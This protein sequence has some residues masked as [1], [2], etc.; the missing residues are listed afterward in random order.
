MSAQPPYDPKRAVEHLMQVTGLGRDLVRAAIRSGELPGEHVGR[1][2]VLPK[3][4]F[5]RFL[6][7]EWT[8]RHRPILE[9][10]PTAPASLIRRKAS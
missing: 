8:P 7:G 6:A 1:S 5:D 4:T 2:Y 9:R 10:V 3:A